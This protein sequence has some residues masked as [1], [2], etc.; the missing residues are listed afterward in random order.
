MRRL[1]H[2]VLHFVVGGV[3][4]FVLRAWAA[5]APSVAVAPVE[6]IER[7]PISADSPRLA[8][9]RKDYVRETDQ[10]VTPRTEAR[11]FERFV[12]EEILYREAVAHGLDRYDRSVRFRLIQKMEFLTD[13][14]VEDEEALYQQALALD[15]GRDDAVIRRMMAHKMKLLLKLGADVGELDDDAL[16]TYLDGHRAEYLHPPLYSLTH[17]YLSHD[18]RGAAAADDARTVYA[19]LRAGRTSIEDAVALG[20]RFPFGASFERRSRR[21]FE[22]QFGS[23]FANAL[24]TL[25]PG[26]WTGPIDSGFGVHL[27]WIED[28]QPARMPTLDEVRSQVRLALR[29]ERRAEAFT[30]K[31]Q[32]LREAYGVASARPMRRPS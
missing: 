22:K 19:T 11:L 18:R 14:R 16:Q 32:A 17:V 20:D 13:H 9:M 3:C 29:T 7:I 5:S 15:L 21:R 25:E 30:Q 27:V 23:E 12:E 31:M 8:Q 6:S 10:P 24:A 2:P 26:A 28:I 1:R 4:L